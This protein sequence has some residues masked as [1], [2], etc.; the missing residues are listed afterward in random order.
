MTR[1]ALCTVRSS[2]SG[3]THTIFRGSTT[4]PSLRI[5]PANPRQTSTTRCTRSLAYPCM[6]IPGSHLAP[7]LAAA[8]TSS[9]PTPQFQLSCSK[10]AVRA[11]GKGE[12]VEGR[13]RQAAH[14]AAADAG[15]E[16]V[17]G[18]DH[19]W[20]DRFSGRP[21]FGIQQGM[22]LLFPRCRGCRPL[23]PPPSEHLRSRRTRSWPRA[24]PPPPPSFATACPP[25]Q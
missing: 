22:L 8:A 10:P 15:S 3:V 16:L 9:G 20:H 12:G 17:E 6:R 7:S 5:P 1:F 13:E 4:Q 11:Y 21:A 2:I 25:R 23:S 19:G 24:A 14:V 18:L